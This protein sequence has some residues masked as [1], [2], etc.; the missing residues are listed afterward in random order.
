M[1]LKGKQKLEEVGNRPWEISK[2]EVERYIYTH[3]HTY[4][5]LAPEFIQLVNTFFKKVLGENKKHV[6][7]FYLK[8]RQ[9][10]WPTI[11]RERD[12][13]GDSVV[14]NLPAMQETQVRF[15]GWEDPV[16]EGMA[17]HSRTVAWRS[18]WTE[19]PGRLQS[20][21]LHRVRHNWSDSATAAAVQRETGASLVA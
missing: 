15:L 9:T 14:K 16:E 7:Y 20:M 11:Y 21:V 6:F 12:F 18:P 5:G 4:I 19:E 3:T 17:N 10:F 8:I 13:P 1:I 2:R